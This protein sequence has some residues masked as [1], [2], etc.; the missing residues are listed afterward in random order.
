MGEEKGGESGISFY[1]RTA[2]PGMLEKTLAKK[3][4]LC[5]IL[6]TA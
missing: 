6:S 3:R 5:H 2:L 1:T 4:G